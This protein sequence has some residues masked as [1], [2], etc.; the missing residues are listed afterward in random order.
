MSLQSWLNHGWL[1]EH[2]TSPQEIRDLLAVVDRD[3]RDCRTSGLSADWRLAI[4]Y[5]AALQAA[6]AALAACGYRAT[7]E[8]LHYRVIQSLELTINAETNLV[9]RLDMFRRKRNAIEYDRAGMVSEQ[10]V[11]EMIAV[12]TEVGDRVRSWLHRN[13]PSL[14][15]E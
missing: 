9:D 8:S 14:L 2:E 11:K 6:K 7:R 4:A 1:S 12:A 3:L 15:R 13:H 10:E 5:N